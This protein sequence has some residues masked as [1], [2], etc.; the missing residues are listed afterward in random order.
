MEAQIQSLIKEYELKAQQSRLELTSFIDSTVLKDPD[1]LSNIIEVLEYTRIE[2]FELTS[3]DKIDQIYKDLEDELD[4]SNYLLN[5]NS[6]INSISSKSLSDAVPQY[7]LL[8]SQISSLPS[9]PLT[10]SFASCLLLQKQFLINSLT[11]KLNLEFTFSSKLVLVDQGFDLT[12][13][14]MIELGEW[15]KIEKELKLKLF[16]FYDDNK[17]NIIK[18]KPLIGKFQIKSSKKKSEDYDQKIESI[19]NFLNFF[20]NFFKKDAEIQENFIKLSENLAKSQA[21]KCIEDESL[22]PKSLIS[23]KSL[24]TSLESHTIKCDLSKIINNC[25]DF[26]LDS[27]KK[28]LLSTQQSHLLHLSETEVAKSNFIISKSCEDFMSLINSSL[29]LSTN[30]EYEI[31]FILKTIKESLILFQ[32]L[33]SYRLPYDS[34]SLTL[35]LSD[36][37]YVLRQVEGLSREMIEI[38]E[39]IKYMADYSDLVAVMRSELV[40]TSERLVEISQEELRNMCRPL[41]FSMFDKNYPVQES[42][43]LR[44]VKYIREHFVV[45]MLPLEISSG[46]IGQVIDS[47]IDVTVDQIL[48]KDDIYQAEYELIKHFFTLIFDIRDVFHG[49]N[50]TKFCKQWDKLEALLE[51]IEGKL[52]EILSMFH[53]KRYDNL[54]TPKQ[55]RKLI[56]ALFENNDKRK[57]ALSQIN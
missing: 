27:W 4:T 31:F 13:K 34:K 45:K 23:T 10:D 19:Q 16:Q 56:E 37:E 35:L 40:Q 22:K 43:L 1:L 33:R 30:S 52:V 26:K 21:E 48:L 2:G 49:Q 39:H 54:F 6:S 14:M 15:E 55:L 42:V 28:S 9:S 44:A 25:K 38:P 46:L 3:L 11:P 5:I 24:E 57:A 47:L 32:A 7:K 17:T 41:D 29:S 50:P 8:Q 53:R 36:T 20:F 51:I 18:T 12:R